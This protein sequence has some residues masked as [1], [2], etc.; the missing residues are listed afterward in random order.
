MR[1]DDIINGEIYRVRQVGK[2]RVVSLEPEQT[3]YGRRTGT[4]YRVVVQPLNA[5]DQPVGDTKRPITADI[6]DLWSE[7]NQA[8]LRAIER[9]ESEASV[10][11]IRLQEAGLQPYRR[12]HIDWDAPGYSASVGEESCRD[13][14]TGGRMRRDQ[15][16]VTFTGRDVV[17]RVLRALEAQ[18]G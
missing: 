13:E 15:P 12:D 2:A 11:A 8:A 16:T 17:E 10:I 18:G 14:A 6:L 1:K 4:R 7:D 9:R 3:G 5:D